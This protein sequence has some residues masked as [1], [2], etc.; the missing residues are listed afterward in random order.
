MTEFL[1]FDRHC[2]LFTQHLIRFCIVVGMLVTGIS[3]VAEN[4][5]PQSGS[6]ALSP[7][8]ELE[9]IVSLTLEPG[10][11]EG[12][13]Q[14]RIHYAGLHFRL[15]KGWYTYWR[16]PGMYGIPLQVDWTGSRNVATVRV[17]WPEPSLIELSGYE[18]VG[19]RNRVIL[20][21]VLHPARGDEPVHIVAQVVFG[22]CREVCIPV[23]YDLVEQLTPAN[24]K[25]DARIVAAI[26]NRPILHRIPKVGFSYE[27]EL[28][29]ENG[30]IRVTSRIDAKGIGEDSLPY[31]VFEY[32]HPNVRFETTKVARNADGTLQAVAE[33]SAESV[34]AINKSELLLTLVSRNGTQQIQGC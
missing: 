34:S 17:L 27:C 11:R 33:A 25:P 15:A 26:R 9:E 6:Y 18:I 1:K 22:V 23:T 13:E 2:K 20:P 19:Y 4:T 10:W 7:F 28:K 29:V 3:V 12:H 14:E 32:E 24:S 5:D 30:R 16:S 8:P 21:L 31:A